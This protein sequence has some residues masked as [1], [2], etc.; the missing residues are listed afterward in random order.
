MRKILIYFTTLFLSAAFL[1]PV[2]VS[3]QGNIHLG[4]LKIVP[5]VKYAPEWNDNI[6]LDADDEKEDYIHNITPSVGLDFTRDKNNYMRL[7][8]GVDIVRYDDYSDNDYE[9]HQLT[10]R[11]KYTSPQGFYI[12]G[13]ENFIDTEDPY[14]SEND[15]NVGVQTERWNNLFK[16][17]T[18]YKF[19]DRFRVELN[20]RNFMQEYDNK[21]DEW[22]NKQDNEPGVAVFYKFMPKTSALFE[23]RYQMREYTDADDSI[24]AGYND[25]TSQ[26]FD[27]H[28]LFLGLHWDTTAK[29]TGDLKFGYGMKNYDNDQNW[30]GQEYED[31]D[32]WLAETRLTYKLRARTRLTGKVSRSV[33]DSSSDD[34]STEYENT[35][36][37]LGIKQ[38]FMERFVFNAN[39]S[40]TFKDYDE[41]TTGTYAGQEREDDQYEGEVGVKYKA[42]DWLT[43]GVNYTYVDRQSNFD[44]EEYTNNIFGFQI[45]AKY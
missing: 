45:A 40:V 14:G 34:G 22:Q 16:L 3:A 13:F 18:G 4:K 25:D 2:C 21:K 27:Y 42:N 15:Y 28:K 30:L 7:G 29:I 20:Y 43:L 19:A 12:K 26:D 17:N 8:Y 24:K 32:T 31:N 41:A 35:K 10:G 33:R 6:F 39:A 44:D 36:L 1:M 38:G 23:Y 5:G 37:G 9:K 11:A